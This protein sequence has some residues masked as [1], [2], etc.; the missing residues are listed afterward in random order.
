[1]VSDHMKRISKILLFL[2][3]LLSGVFVALEEYF[4]FLS[5]EKLDIQPY[6]GF[7]LDGNGRFLLDSHIVTH[8]SGSIKQVSF[9]IIA[10]ARNMIA[11]DD[12]ERN[13]INMR[14]LKWIV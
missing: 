6:Y 5:I 1:M 9:D 12:T 2:L 3:P 13:T 10:F 4:M 8:N 14:V 11:D 7:T